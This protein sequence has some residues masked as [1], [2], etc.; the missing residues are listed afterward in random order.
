MKKSLF[1]IAGLLLAGMAG[2]T[3]PATGPATKATNVPPP[4]VP[5]SVTPGSTGTEETGGQPPANEVPAAS[6]DA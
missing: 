2:C 6:I 1:L 4:S 5:S 3:K